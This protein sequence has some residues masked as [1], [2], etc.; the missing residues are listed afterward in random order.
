MERR[1][2]AKYMDCAH[3]GADHRAVDARLRRLGTVGPRRF[4]Q[5]R[6]L[7]E[8]YPLPPRCW[9]FSD[10]DRTHTAG[11]S[12]M[13][14]HYRR[15]VGRLQPD[16]FAP[17][18]QPRPRPPSGRQPVRPVALVRALASRPHRTRPPHPPTA[19]PDDGNRDRRETIMKVLLAGATG[20]IGKLLVARL[21][22]AG[23]TVIGISRSATGVEWLE[24]EGA[25]AIH[26]DVLD[27]AGLLQAVAG[28]RAG[29]VIHQATALA[30][31]PLFHRDLHTTDRLRDEGTSALVEVA[32]LVGATRF[33]TQSFFLGYGYRDLGEDLVTEDTEFS[34]SDRNRA[35]ERHLASMRTNESLVRTN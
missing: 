5:P 28:T 10:R 6:R 30:G 7:A 27:R 29:A 23:H 33:I 16:Q 4:C 22:E 8:S 20:T 26:A 34:Q 11:D 24:R 21:R 31:L 25:T 12:D 32:H 13:E 9:S 3:H 2:N 35:V 1:T 15:G 19:Q 18:T 14:R 17:R